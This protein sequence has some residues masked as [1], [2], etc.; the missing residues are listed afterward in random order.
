MNTAIAVR[1]FITLLAVSFLAEDQSHAV[2][3]SAPPQD[4]REEARFEM[5]RRI[6]ERG[7]LEQGEPK[8]Y[9]KFLVHLDNE[10]RDA[11]RL[12]RVAADLTTAARNGIVNVVGQRRISIGELNLTL[13]KERELRKLGAD[14]FEDVAPT[15]LRQGLDADLLYFGIIYVE[16]AQN[17]ARTYRFRTRLLDNTARRDGGGPTWV[18]AQAP[19]GISP[20]SDFAPAVIERLLARDFFAMA[21]KFEQQVQLEIK[22]P[23]GRYNDVRDL[24]TRFMD[25]DPMY[26]IDSLRHNQQDRL[27]SVFTFSY[28]GKNYGDFADRLERALVEELGLKVGDN[29]GWKLSE[30]RVW[31]EFEELI[32]RDDGKCRDDDEM[33]VELEKVELRFDGGIPNYL[34]NEIEKCLV[35]HGV[36]L[37]ACD[38]V[39]MIQ[40]SAERSEEGEL[41]LSLRLTG[42]SGDE[43]Q[44]VEWHGYIRSPDDNIQKAAFIL[45]NR[46]VSEIENPGNRRLR[47]IEV[48]TNIECQNARHAF[49][50]L[51][52]DIQLGPA[53]LRAKV[54]VISRCK[55]SSNTLVR[56]R[57]NQAVLNQILARLQPDCFVR[58]AGTRHHIE[59]VADSSHNKRY[60]LATR[61]NEPAAAPAVDPPRGGRN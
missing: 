34:T 2:Q 12:Q 5:D 23:R 52:K 22:H 50:L 7:Y 36:V 45:L 48:F 33:D 14:M 44:G 47:F 16:T 17:G 55:E 61:I 28:K 6:F 43:R 1:W 20:H 26:S 31:F 38:P 35:D 11:E 25:T 49:G 39:F 27:N 59:F 40:L 32:V 60:I 8:L 18:I 30:S 13:D 56:I 9:I 15:L 57:A 19:Y 54:D 4:T 29:S 42:A 58:E 53:E 51:L 3:F 41:I 37:T 46:F 10:D 21:V 24:I